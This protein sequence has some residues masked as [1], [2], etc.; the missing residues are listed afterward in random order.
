MSTLNAR[1]QD[2]LPNPQLDEISMKMYI[3]I[4]RQD[5]TLVQCGVQASHAAVEYASQ[6]KDNPQFLNWVKNH[7]TMIF[8]EASKDD[9]LKMEDYFKYIGK[10]SARFIEPDIGDVLTAVAFEPIKTLEGKVIFGK[11]KLLK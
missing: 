1:Q 5:L 8:L 11:F 6:F 2:Y 10:T 4:N 9:I 3:M 7:K